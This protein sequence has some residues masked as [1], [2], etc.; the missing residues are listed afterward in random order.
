MNQAKA[1]AEALKDI[2]FVRVYC[3]DLKRAHWTAQQVLEANASLRAMN[4]REVV[5][6]I[7][8]E[9]FFGD[10]EGMSWA[11]SAAMR[12]SSED[13]REVSFSSCGLSR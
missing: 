7:L 6:P 2:P 10:A 1:V 9:Q 8:R 4:A 13:R 11:D 3:S 12:E 5:D